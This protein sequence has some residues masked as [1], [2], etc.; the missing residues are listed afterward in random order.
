MR[1]VLRRR[2]RIRHKDR[3]TFIPVLVMRRRKMVEK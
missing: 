1:V 3:R 2:L